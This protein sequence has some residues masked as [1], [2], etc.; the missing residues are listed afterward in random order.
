MAEEKRPAS[1][2]T[3]R[4]LEQMERRRLARPCIKTVDMRGKVPGECRPFSHGGR[5]HYL[6]DLSLAIFKRGLEVHGGA[7][8]E[9]TYEAIVNGPHTNKAL[10]QTAQ[11]TPAVAA[12]AAPVET[13]PPPPPS[14]PEMITFG[15]LSKRREDRVQLSTPL[16][17]GTKGHDYR[18][19]SV[20]LSV[21]GL[22][23]HLRGRYPVAIDDIVVITMPE[24][25]GD[26][27]PLP[28]LPYRVRHADQNGPDLYLHMSLEQGEHRPLAEASINDFI[29]GYRARNRLD[30]TEEVLDVMGRLHERLLCENLP[31]L[32]LYLG[33]GPRLLAVAAASANSTLSGLFAVSDG[34]DFSPLDQ[35]PLLAGLQ[36]RGSVL[37]LAR[38]GADGIPQVQPLL[39]QGPE[40]QQ[41]LSSA[42]ADRQTRV[43]SVQVVPPPLRKPS[44]RRLLGHTGPALD[45]ARWEPHYRE[46]ITAVT[47]VGMV[48]D[49]TTQAQALG[50]TPRSGAATPPE[51]PPGGDQPEAVDFRRLRARRENRYRAKAKVVVVAGDKH[52]GQTVDISV[53]GAAVE[54]GRPLNLSEGSDLFVGFPALQEKRPQLALMRVP[55]RVVRAVP[56]THLALRRL[57]D[58]C[59]E[60]VNELFQDLIAQN[61]KRVPQAEELPQEII[62]THAYEALL[63]ENLVAVPFFFGRDEERGLIV[64]SIAVADETAL[65]LPRFFRQYDTSYDFGPLL[66]SDFR[67]ALSERFRLLLRDISVTGRRPAPLE[68]EMFC[69]K[70]PPTEGAPAQTACIMASGLAAEKRATLIAQLLKLP[71]RL[72][73]KVIATKVQSPEARILEQTVHAMHRLSTIDALNLD[74]L[75][76]AIDGC[77]LMFDITATIER[78]HGA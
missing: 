21:H 67:V 51:W 33:A 39:Q 76:H 13:P 71:D 35:R 58:K 31:T 52:A 5:T 20:N 75:V 59:S 29:R 11:S 1:E 43:L 65:A 30:V 24:L 57:A 22:L 26:K 48:V 6:D 15:Y 18:G 73:I 53:H 7:F 77:G 40:L 23:A 47:A 14:G 8:I 56:A 72:F 66:G 64:H 25:L 62:A 19:N 41:R 9:G 42:L 16:V 63:A 70:R 36:E 4:F 74:D 34:H 46:V 49:V 28:P 12:A 2:Q 44:A 50:A 55:Y 17:V 60:E 32:T 68:F 37:L 10:R 27:P 78:L 69:Y 38:R 61:S 3:R 45:N 54:V